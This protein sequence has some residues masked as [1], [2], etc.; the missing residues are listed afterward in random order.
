ML[1][2]IAFSD[3]H[4]QY[5]NLVLPDADVVICAGDFSAQGHFRDAMEFATW[6]KSLPHKH[7]IVIAGNHDE[8]FEYKSSKEIH[9]VIFGGDKSIH[10]LLDSWI[11]I[12]G[13]T[14]YGTPWTMPFNNWS[15]MYKDEGHEF[16]M[17]DNIP[18]DIDVLITHGPPYGCGD[19]LPDDN[20]NVGSLKLRQ[21]L[22]GR[23][24]SKIVITGHIHEG[25]GQHKLGDKIIYNVSVLDGDY[26]LVNPVTII[27]LSQK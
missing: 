24:N 1:K 2:I 20:K 12:D 18:T 22:E 10:Y 23:I 6:L 3:I 15:F 19:Y 17:V 27:E 7:K 13:I 4:G 5:K 26:K 25:F 9:D 16:K 8:F 14:F 21:H 11:V